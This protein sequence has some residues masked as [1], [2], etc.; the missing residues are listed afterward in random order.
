MKDGMVDHIMFLMWAN[1]SLPAIAE[2]RLVESDSG[3]ILSP[4]TAPEI[5][6]PATKA[7][8][9]PIAW[10]TAK[11]ANPIVEMVVKP[12]PIETP[13]SEQTR[14]VEGTNHR[15][16]IILKPITIIDGIIP[17]LVQTAIRAPIRMKIKIGIIA[18]PIPSWIPLWR[19]SQEAPRSFAQSMIKAMTK[20]TGICGESP[21]LITAVPKITNI[22]SRILTA[23]LNLID[24]I[25]Q[26]SLIKF[27]YWLLFEM[28]LIT[29]NATTIFHFFAPP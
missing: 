8:L 4:K 28:K 27:I 26:I 9:I 11:S 1:K 29:D 13:T 18:V 14:K 5:I 21:N 12:L 22:I 25:I 3:D 7:G 17:A 2:A 20:R 19:S 15:A 10:P 16:L 24:F 23:S 6:E